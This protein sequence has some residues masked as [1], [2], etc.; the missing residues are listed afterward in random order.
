MKLFAHPDNVCMSYTQHMK[1]SMKFFFL[2]L[3]GAIKAFIHAIIP[4]LCVTSTSDINK[5]VTTLLKENGCHNDDNDDND[6][7]Q[8]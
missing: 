6:E 8:T 5:T 4:D 1:L 7:K 3:K 2:F